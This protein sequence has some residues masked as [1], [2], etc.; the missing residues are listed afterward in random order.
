[1][2]RGVGVLDFEALAS[3]IA[4]AAALIVAWTQLLVYWRLLAGKLAGMMQGTRTVVKSVTRDRS[5]SLLFFV[6]A[7]TGGMR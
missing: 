5:A 6:L 7:N 2:R 1:M 4:D 3:D